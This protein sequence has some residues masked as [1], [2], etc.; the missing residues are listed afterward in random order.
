MSKTIIT[1]SREFGSGG[2]YIGEQVAQR[3]GYS[4]YD[5][6]LIEKVAEETGLDKVFVENH[7]E[8][9]PKKFAMAYAFVGRDKYGSSMSD[10]LYSVQRKI[11][12]NIADEGN[13][14]IIGRCADYILADRPNSLHIFI[15]G[16]MDKKIERIKTLY[17][18]TDAEAKK[19]I[20]DMDKRRSVHYGYYTDQEWGKAQNYTLSL[21]SSALGID[22]CVDI[23]SKLAET[24]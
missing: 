10:Y 9:S 22:N 16:N 2:R 18:K 3:L 14:V 23:I 11:V 5:K 7:G 17:D 21:N 15:H 8:Y 20:S 24:L 19:L 13:C 6:N 1:I 12:L 4:Y